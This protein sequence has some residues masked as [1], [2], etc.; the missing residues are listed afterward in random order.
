MVETQMTHSNANLEF[1]RNCH[2]YNEWSILGLVVGE[3]A[4]IK[5]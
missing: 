5:F 1:E 3:Y 2:N 4:D